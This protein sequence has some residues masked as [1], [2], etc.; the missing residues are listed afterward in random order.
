MFVQP[1]QTLSMDI[2]LARNSIVVVVL[3]YLVFFLGIGKKIR[4]FQ[5][6]QNKT[7]V[8][9]FV[10]ISGRTDA[11][12]SQQCF[13]V[14]AEAKFYPGA[15]LTLYSLFRQEAVD[16]LLAEGEMAIGHMN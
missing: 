7:K 1:F 2:V 12:C 15:F 10:K 6:A 5:Q 8:Q 4:I 13:R 9:G 14:D 16:I 3:E 11:S